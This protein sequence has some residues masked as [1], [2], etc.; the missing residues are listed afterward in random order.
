MIKTVELIIFV[1]LLIFSFFLGVKYSGTVRENMSWLQ[2]K[3]DEELELP[4]LSNELQE[5]LIETTPE[6]VNQMPMD[7]IQNDESI[8]EP[9]AGK[10]DENQKQLPQPQTNATQSNPSN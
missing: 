7:Q 4:N 8:I 5:G 2:N 9:E 3:N 1:G 6:S 10:F